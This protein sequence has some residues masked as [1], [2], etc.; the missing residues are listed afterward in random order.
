MDLT[1]TFQRYAD[2][3]VARILT[4]MDRDPQSPTFGCFD[5]NYWH[6]K[7]RDYPSSILQQGAF[8][9]EAIANDTIPSVSGIPDEWRIGALNA[10]ARQIDSQ[11][12]VDE[13]YPYEASY[14]AAAFGLY[15]VTRILWQ[16]EKTAP[17]LAKEVNRE[18]LEWLAHHLASRLETEASN[19]HAAGV[20]GLAFAKRLNLL[21]SPK[22]ALEEQT[23]QL[24]NNQHSEG[25]FKEYGGPDFGYLTVTLDVLVDYYEITQ[26]ERAIAAID[27]AVEFLARL[28]G[29]DYK[30]PSTLNSRNTDYVVPYGLVKT[31]QRNPL[32]AWLVEV[33]FSSLDQ[34]SHFVWATDDRYHCHYLF[35]SIVRAIPHLKAM[36][37]SQTPKFWGES[38]WLEGCGYQVYWSKEQRWNAYVAARKGGLVRIHQKGELDPVVDYG[39]RIEKENTLWTTN[40]WTQDWQI[41]QKGDRII[42]RGNCQKT[43][44]HVPSPPKHLV[45][46]ILAF[47]LREK[48]IPLLK[49]VMI[50]RPG[51]TDGPKFERVIS[52]DSNGV[53]IKEHLA[54]FPGAMVIPSPRQNLRHVASADSFSREEWLVSLMGDR[55][56]SLEKDIVID[57]QWLANQ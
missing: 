50:F 38:V 39:W 42:I 51:V 31:A 46:R 33:L 9:L 47:L 8:T 34:P 56:Y 18:P 10:L 35:A 22:I 40:W 17:H 25:W 41:E 27:R 37:P 3:Q 16:W 7:I 53:K 23:E 13:Y 26:D 21:S 29:A 19:Q 55:D 11:G 32:A 54:A 20:T 30:L 1:A 48:V 36:Q 44:Y 52:F 12:R 2:H 5:R 57:N 6:Y 49:R 43:Q 24:F 14:P 45:L 15:A 4:Q 28:V